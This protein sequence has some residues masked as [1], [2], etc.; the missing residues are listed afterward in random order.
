MNRTYRLV[1]NASRQVV[2]AAEHKAARGRAAGGRAARSL[3]AAVLIAGAG[4]AHALPGNGQVTAGSGSVSQSGS[5]MTVSQQSQKLALDWTSFSI[6]AGETVKF[7]QPSS[8]AIALNRVIG[9]DASQIYGNLQANGQVFL[10]NPNGVLFGRGAQVDVGGLVASTLN[11]SNADFL[12]GNYKFSGGGSAGIV[13]QGSLNA[14]SGGYIALLGG[15]VSNQ[16]TISAQLGTV[17]LGAGSAVTLDFYGGKLLNLQVDQGVLKALVDNRQLII[18]DGGT[19]IMSAAARDA[20]LDTVV[21]NSGVI[22]ARTV[23]NQGGVIRLLGD[24]AGGTVQVAGTLDASAPAGGD[25]GFIETSGAHVKV[26]DAASITTAAP[27]GRAGTW[28]IDPADYIIAASGGDISGTA[29]GNALNSGN[30]SILSNSGTV[31]P[32]GN[33]DIFVNDG[34]T[35]SSANTLTLQAV[36]DINLNA[37]IAAAN[38][39]LTLNA[40]AGIAAPAAVNVHTF[41]LQSGAWRQVGALPAFGA[42]DFQLAGGSFLRALSGDGSAASPYALTDVY[43]LQGMGSSAALLGKSYTLANDI[44]AAGTVNWNAGAGFV[45]VGDATTAFTGGFNGNDHTVSGLTV[46]LPNNEYVGLFGYIGSGATVSHVS[47]AAAS[48]LGQGYV[49]ALA[50][51]NDGSVSQVSAGGSVSNVY[52]SNVGGLLGYDIGGLIGYNTGSIDHAGA[53]ARVGAGLG[54]SYATG[55]LVG[56]NDGTMDTV[57]A[58]GA[59]GGADGTGGLV[60]VNNGTVSNGSAAGAVTGYGAGGLAGENYGAISLSSASGAVTGSGDTGGLVGYSVG[61]LTDVHATGNVIAGGGGGGGLVGYNTGA[62]TRAWASGSVNG[63]DDVGGLIGNNYTGGSVSVAYATGA[64]TGTGNNVGG[65]VGHNNSF[66]INSPATL[67]NVYATGAVKGRDYVGGLVGFNDFFS[68]VTHAY[69]S[70]TVTGG[71]GQQHV[72]GIAGSGTGGSFSDAYWDKTSSGRTIAIGGGIAPGVTGLTSMQAMTQSSYAHFDF[73][74]TWT[75]YPGHTRPLLTAFMTPVT[76]TAGD[77]SKTYDGTAYS[78]GAG[79]A[80]PAGVDS[81]LLLGTTTYGG[82]S[83]GARNAGSYG[84][85]LS[86]LYSTQQ[87]YLISYASGT[88]TISPAPLTYVADAATRNAGQALTGFS[89]SISGLVGGDTL[90]G[91][92]TGTLAWTTPAGATSAPGQYAIEGG[93]LTL[94]SANYRPIAQA[95]GNAQALTLLP[96]PVVTPPSQP[97]GTALPPAA[98]TAAGQAGNQGSNIAWQGNAQDVLLAGGTEIYS[99][100]PPPCTAEEAQDRQHNG[101]AGACGNSTARRGLL[102]QNHGIRLPEGVSEGD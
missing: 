9:N 62:I 48:V 1:R 85:S 58:T 71:S 70:G 35:W 69:S 102:L 18:A 11:I 73:A 41:I 76:V 100:P 29:L 26:D 79:Y 36:R 12:A 96:A 21:N 8:S 40:A 89:G 53:S 83:Q 42:S 23:Q 68:S 61:T 81:S 56:A 6:A 92:S 51:Q 64:V 66:D 101:G 25:G 19:V 14:A 16:G 38:G 54:G 3:C 72:G 10:I 4:A 20:L 63:T 82:S 44:N 50:G 30:V 93:G 75:I 59:V 5:T 67:T 32:A 34:V 7:V 39:G 87:G 90:A 60:G 13:N 88:L 24:P 2:P 55:G 17:A 80:V 47:L 99:A 31:N 28:L 77:A 49:G 97:G 74:N 94:T 91:I 37:P 57:S 45:P 95:A 22:E 15:S 33:G 65:L 43:G 46:N 78:G 86:G 84:I 52:D 27:A 98:Q